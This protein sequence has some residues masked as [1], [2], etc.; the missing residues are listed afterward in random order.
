M[1]FRNTPYC[2]P[3]TNS[4][5][6]PTAQD[7]GTETDAGRL[8]TQD[9]VNHF[10]SED[11]R[12]HKAQLARM[13]NEL[14]EVLKNQSL[15]Q[16][17]RDSLQATLDDISK[18]LRTKEEELKVRI[19][20]L[21]DQ[22]TAQIA[23]KQNIAQQWEARYQNMVIERSL[24]DAAAQGDAFNPQ[25]IVML[26]KH[27]SKLTEV[28]D[29]KTSK[30]SGDY[31]PMVE[32]QEKNEA[33]ETIITQR[34][35]EEAITWLKKNHPNL[36]KSNVVSGLGTNS[37]TGGL[38]PGSDGRIDARKLSPE[39]YMELRRKNPAALGLK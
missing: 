15:T 33:G 1:T 17:E 16:K 29:P 35:P 13:E 14:K 3:Y 39:Q 4:Q 30:P 8:F 23:E 9:E 7:V 28:L 10:L 5:E 18:Q 32:F 25:Q 27:Q 31:K 21:E 24:Y 6:E 12:R 19:K 37:A 26:L 36:F 38:T 22:Y 2:S 20:Q 11:R 34:T